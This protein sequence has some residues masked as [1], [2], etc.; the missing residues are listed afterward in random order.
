MIDTKGWTG[1]EWTY[2]VSLYGMYHYYQQNGD[3]TMRKIIDDWFADRFAERN[4]DE[5]RQYDG[6]VFNAGIL[7]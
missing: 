4:N 5:K 6:A 1:W 7:L 2:G 3:Q